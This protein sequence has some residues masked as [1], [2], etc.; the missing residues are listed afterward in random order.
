MQRNQ[1]R[2]GSFRGRGGYHRSS[3]RE[4]SMWDLLGVSRLDLKSHNTRI[5]LSDLKPANS[6]W[7]KTPKGMEGVSAA[8]AKAVGLFSGPGMKLEP[9]FSQEE[10]KKRLDANILLVGK[11]IEDS[12]LTPLHSKFSRMVIIKNAKDLQLPLINVFLKKYIQGFGFQ[13]PGEL[14]IRSVDE[15]DE[16][17]VETK[18]S[19]IATVLMSLNGKSLK[20]FNDIPSNIQR[21]N[22]FIQFDDPLKTNNV[23]LNII[24][25]SPRSLCC[26]DLPIG[27]L[28]EDLIKKLEKYGDLHSL[29]VFNDSNT[30]FLEY[31]NT[32]LKI[33]DIIEN[34]RFD[35]GLKFFPV[36]VNNETN[37]IQKVRLTSSNFNHMVSDTTSE[38]TKQKQTAMIQLLNMLNIDDLMSNDTYN[39]L[40]STLQKDFGTFEGFIKLEISKPKEKPTLNDMNLTAGRVFVKFQTP[41]QATNCLHSLAG[42]LFC[43]RTVIGGYIDEVDFNRHII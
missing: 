10:I 25:E 34:I 14:D 24:T 26:N 16:I 43:N 31:K 17:I 11:P 35:E 20:E 22:E 18:N 15:E 39:F 40:F 33:T 29:T 38:M 9:K 42:K 13:E 4:S 28:R 30:M 1:R 41:Q 27:S 12:L 37:Y 32:S 8:K 3:R 7:G 36:C 21:P 19:L 2:G 5:R 23:L 6:L